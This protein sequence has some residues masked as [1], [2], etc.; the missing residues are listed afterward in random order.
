MK[1]TKTIRF[2]ARN[3]EMITINIHGIEEVDEFTY[4]GATI[5]KEGGGMKDLQNRL[6]KARGAFVRL[7][8]IWKQS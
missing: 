2:N 5:C 1:K 4:V 8:K 3:Q 6:S 7:R